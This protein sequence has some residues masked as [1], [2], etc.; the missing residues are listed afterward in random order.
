MIVLGL[1]SSC[2]DTAVAIFDSDQGVLAQRVHTQTDV[3]ADFGGVVPELASRDHLQQCLPLVDSCLQ[4]ASLSPEKI[5]VIAFTQGPGLIGSLLVGAST[6]QALAMAWQ[7]P[8]IGVHHLEGHIMAAFLSDPQPSYPFVALLVSGGHSQLIAVRAFGDYH[9][10]G[11]SVDDAA[12][13]AFDK[14]AKL[15]GLGFPGGAALATLAA[16]GNPNADWP[17]PRPMR[18]QPTNNFSFSGLKTHVRE[19]IESHDLSEQDKSD[20][21]LAFQTAVIDTL[22][23]K[24]W[25]AMDE[26]GFKTLVCVGGVSANHALRERLKTEG[27]AKNISIFYPDLAYCTDNAAMIAVAGWQRFLRGE[28]SGYAIVPK[29]RWPLVDLSA[30]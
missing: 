26:V 17:M 29:A 10:L 19:L 18:H 28:Q 4:Q 7:K 27:E 15:L 12:G 2:D 9:L 22:L 13:E 8:T 30:S 25:R 6:A 20:V 11:E 3:H 5:D 1:E 23:C 24:T 14:T 16:S 21:A